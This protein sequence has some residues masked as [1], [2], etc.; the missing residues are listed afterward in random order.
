MMGCC[1]SKKVDIADGTVKRTEGESLKGNC[2]SRAGLST[3]L[4]TLYGGISDAGYI[5]ACK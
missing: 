3:L 5:E 4:I 2:C 1:L